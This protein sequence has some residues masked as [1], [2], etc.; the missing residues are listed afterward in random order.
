M[1]KYKIIFVL[2]F[3]LALIFAVVAAEDRGVDQDHRDLK[4]KLSKSGDVA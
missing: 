4:I 3:G 2:C 1:K